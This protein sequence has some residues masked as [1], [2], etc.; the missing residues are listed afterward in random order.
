MSRIAFH[1]GCTALALAGTAAPAAAQE[2]SAPATE[3]AEAAAPEPG[4]R[5]VYT[6]ADF[7]RFAPRSALDMVQRIP[8]FSIQE[9]LDQGRGLGEASGNVLING[10]RIST[11]SDLVADR[12]SRISA[13]NVIRIELADGATF[14]VPGLSGRIANVVARSTGVAGQFDWQPQ[15]AG[16]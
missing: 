7:A 2:A 9:S 14:D 3:P 4:E 5:L 6:P 16:L 1:C 15:I 10:E 12:L 13:A 8:G 11:K